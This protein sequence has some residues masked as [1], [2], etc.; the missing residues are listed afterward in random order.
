MQTRAMKDAAM[1]IT[2]AR[3]SAMTATQWV[4]MDAPGLAKM[5]MATHV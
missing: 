2:S 1:A 3:I 4:A 5:K